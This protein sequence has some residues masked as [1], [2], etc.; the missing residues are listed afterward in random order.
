MRNETVLGERL[1]WFCAIL[2]AALLTLAGCAGTPKN[3]GAPDGLVADVLIEKSEEPRPDWILNPPASDSEFMYFIGI[4]RKHATEQDARDDAMMAA[5]SEFAKYCG[6]EIQEL[7]K[8]LSVSFGL[9]GEVE[10]PTRSNIRKSKEEVYARISRV[11]SKTNYYERYGASGKRVVPTAWQYWTLVSVPRDEVQKVEAWRREQEDEARKMVAALINDSRESQARIDQLLNQSNPLAAL[12]RVRSSWTSLIE[13]GARLDGYGWP[14]N[15]PANIQPVTQ[16][17]DRV[18]GRAQDVMNTLM[19]DTGRYSGYVYVAAGAFESNVPVWALCFH[20]NTVRPVPDLPLVLRADAEGA[21]GR[22]LARA[23]TDVNG[24]AVFLVPN[25]RSGAYKV[26]IDVEAPAIANIGEGVPRMLASKNSTLSVVVSDNSI[27]ASILVATR[28]IFQGPAAANLPVNKVFLGP[29]TYEA[30]DKDT[31]QGSPFA[32]LVKTELRNQVTKIQGLIV[33]EPKTRTRSLLDETQESLSRGA[34]VVPKM[35]SVTAQAVMDGAE[36][37]LKAQYSRIGG[38]IK[39]VLQLL[40]SGSEEVILATA[41]I[42]IPASTIPPG[43]GVVPTLLPN[44]ESVPGVTK[45]RPITLQVTSQ[46]GDG[47]TYVEGQKVSYF[48]SA[49]QDAYILLVYEDAQRNLVQILPN[50][51][52][53]PGFYKAGKFFKIPDDK[54]EFE[55][56][57]TPPFGTERLWAFAASRPFPELQGREFDNGKVLEQDME[58]ILNIVRTHGL[59]A[60]VA[61]GEAQTILTTV[62]K[63]P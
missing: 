36:G 26:M 57:I 29:V 9:S 16:E 4:S 33:V 7:Q 27:P 20:N 43:L 11:R 17:I 12:G 54:D 24:Q 10:D 37:A 5:R 21:S 28:Q 6:V 41:L 23:T 52:S 31:R 13:S 32:Q 47:E 34:G 3:G 1:S 35:Q 55:F 30:D 25:I 39:L 40:K 2:G 48:F 19:L 49:N 61:Y 45:A 15:K 51:Y 46:S 8:E 58:A 44:Y 38:E 63:N 60:D 56:E 14:Y 59:R 53:G 50:R 18:R 22:L 62:P 42:T